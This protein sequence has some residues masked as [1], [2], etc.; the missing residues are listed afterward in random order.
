MIYTQEKLLNYLQAQNIDYKLYEHAPLRTC[1]DALKVA[2]TLNIP[3]TGINRTS[4][5]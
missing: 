2:D 4:A 3:G 5:N 1:E